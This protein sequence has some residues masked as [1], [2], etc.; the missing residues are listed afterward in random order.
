[1]SSL[2][3]IRFADQFVMYLLIAY[4]FSFSSFEVH[5]LLFGRFPVYLCEICG[6]YLFNPFPNKPWFLHICSTS[7]LEAMWE[8]E[9]LPVM[10][11]SSFSE[12]FYTCFEKISAVSFGLRLSSAASF[13]LEDLGFVVWEEV[14]VCSIGEVVTK[15]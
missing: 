2:Q 12:R 10:G 6:L 7:L 5:N 1:M 4:V 3:N 8:K 13:C 15:Q 14:K 11:D 9:K